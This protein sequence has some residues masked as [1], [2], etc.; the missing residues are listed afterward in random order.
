MDSCYMGGKG[1]K[2]N[3]Q[4]VLILWNYVKLSSDGK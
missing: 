4:V 3:F 1:K 2:Y